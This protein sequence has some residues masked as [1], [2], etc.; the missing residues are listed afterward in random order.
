MLG[1]YTNIAFL[2][3]AQDFMVAVKRR[4]FQGV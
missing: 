1:I 2:V 4:S 3:V